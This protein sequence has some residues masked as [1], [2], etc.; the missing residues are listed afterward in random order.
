MVNPQKCYMLY[1]NHCNKR[2]SEDF[3]GLIPLC[4]P[5]HLGEEKVKILLA[6]SLVSLII[7]VRSF[8]GWGWGG[9]VGWRGV[10][11]SS[12]KEKLT[13]PSS[14]NSYSPCP[15]LPN[16]QK[17]LYMYLLPRSLKISKPS[18]QIPKTSGRA[19]R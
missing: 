6:H 10:T 11:A 16:S 8:P 1:G 2:K 12:L 5:D 3:F 18:L 9:G 13:F 14:L 19:P 7:W 15:L 17:G 4:V